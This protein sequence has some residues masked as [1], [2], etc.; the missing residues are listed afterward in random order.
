MRLYIFKTLKRVSFTPY[1]KPYLLIFSI[2][3]ISIAEG[4]SLLKEVW[5]FKG[6]DK[7]Q[8]SPVVIGDA[9]Y[10]GCNDGYL[11]VIESKTGK[12]I[13]KFNAGEAIERNVIAWQSK[14]ILF[15][16]KNL[17]VV[18]IDIGTHSEIW[19]TRVEGNVLSEPETGDNKVFVS[20]GKKDLI[21]LDINTGKECW[22]FSSDGKITSAPTFSK[23]KVC[24]GDKDG[25]LYMVSSDKGNRLWL[26]STQKAICSKPVVKNN[27][28]LIFSK[29]GHLNA[30]NEENGQKLWRYT[31]NEVG[32]IDMG[33]PLVM[34]KSIYFGANDF[35]RTSLETGM[36]EMSL[37]E[38]YHWA[39]FVKPVFSNGIIIFIG[40]YFSGAKG[41]FAINLKTQKT[42]FK[43]QIKG[44]TYV[45]P[46]CV[47]NLLLLS[48]RDKGLTA[49]DIV[50]YYD[51]TVMAETSEMSKI[52]PEN[53]TL[54]K[55]T[56]EDKSTSTVESSE[57]KVWSIEWVKPGTF[58]KRGEYVPIE[59]PT[60]PFVAALNFFNPYGITLRRSPYFR[61]NA[62][63]ENWIQNESSIIE[64]VEYSFFKGYRSLHALQDILNS[65]PNAKVNFDDF[66]RFARTGKILG[67]IGITLDI[68]GLTSFFVFALKDSPH[69]NEKMAIGGLSVMIVGLGLGS[70]GDFLEAKAFKSLHKACNI[71]SGRD[72]K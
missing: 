47:D 26:F 72:K 58:R 70:S 19:R 23:N 8:S 44:L 3:S 52:S 17:E 12:Q 55:D 64:G 9:L 18:A 16:T 27:T 57:N 36:K 60:A 45:Q 51:M 43:Q 29:D 7:I 14:Y 54:S 4:T 22:R 68:A 37:P 28:V 53:V 46:L 5:T 48:I 31:V 67:W 59:K 13:W 30:L 49:F 20:N 65:N 25:N 40:K 63:K 2:V 1:L 6:N 10:F 32:L 38:D 34:D 11:Y 66:D 71:F 33:E 24:F 21:A 56:L 15:C 35:M 69:H 62:T 50:S 42:A 61:L 41:I 39:G